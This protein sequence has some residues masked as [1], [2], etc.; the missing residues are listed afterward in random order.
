MMSH[1]V[2]VDGVQ[3]VFVVVRPAIRG[4]FAGVP[5]WINSMAPPRKALKDKWLEGSLRTDRITAADLE[6]TEPGALPASR[7]KCPASV[8]ADPEAKA[9]WN[10]AVKTLESRGTLTRGD[11]ST[12]TVFALCTSRYL[13]ANADVTARGFEVEVVRV[14]KKGEEYSTSVPNPSLRILDACERQL[15]ALQKTL[16]M[17]P[18]DRTKVKR[19]KPR[20]TPKTKENATLLAF[21]GLAGYDPD[22]DKNDDTE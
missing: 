18:A 3:V 17:T 4:R 5:A 14:N 10:E 6:D 12:L 15:L 2:R 11:A 13:K 19:T 20:E 9:A 22:K 8:K 7:P 1:R 16:G 21:P